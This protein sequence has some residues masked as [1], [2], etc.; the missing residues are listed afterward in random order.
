MAVWPAA[1]DDLNGRQLRQFT[2]PDGRVEV[3]CAAGDEFLSAAWELMDEYWSRVS[4]RQLNQLRGHLDNLLPAD[5]K[6]LGHKPAEAM[7]RRFAEAFFAARNPKT[8]LIPHS[9]GGWSPAFLVD[10]RG[11]QPVYLID[12]AVELLEWFPDDPA[13]LANCTGLAE[14]TMKYFDFEFERGRKGGMWAFVDVETGEPKGP[15]TI[16]LWHGMV[17]EAFAYLSRRTGQRKYLDWADQKMEF[18]WRMRL[19]QNLPILSD[20]FLPTVA[21]M[22]DGWTSDTDTLYYVRKLFRISELSGNPKYRDWAMAVTDLWNDRAW[23][24]SWGHFIRKLR[25]DGTPAVDTLYGDAKYNTLEI[26]LWAYKVTR[27][28]KYLNRFKLAWRNLLRMGRD[29]LVAEAMKQG[30]MSRDGTDVQQTGFLSILLRGYEISADKELLAEAELFGR[31]VL[32]AGRKSWRLEGCQAGH[33]FLRLA[34]ARRP[35]GRAVVDLPARGAKLLLTR[36]GQT[37][38]DANVPGD[39]A[40]LYVPQGRYALEI[41]GNGKTQRRAL[42]VEGPIS[43]AGE[44]GGRFSRPEPPGARSTK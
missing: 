10:I 28:D 34:I 15:V 35:I 5:L 41:S 1:A 30:K 6:R 26:L 42:D 27:D 14:T 19:N 31:R 20:V 33:A 36:D 38:L 39:V 44:R 11:K 13:L 40:V 2:R 8:G 16:T 7:M 32:A 43:D 21:V 25:S 24:A 17:G 3:Y 4:Q 9:Y 18:V 22:N 29:G 12:R 37:I 23:N